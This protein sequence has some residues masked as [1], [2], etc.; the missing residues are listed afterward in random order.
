MHHDV[1]VLLRQLGQARNEPARGKRGH[2]RQRERAALALVGHHVE[3]VALQPLQPARHLA[4]IVRT[5]GRQ[6]HA[7]AGAAKQLHAQKLFQRLDL[8]RHG[9]LRKRKLLRGAGV[10]LVA[11]GD[12]KTGQGLGRWN[13]AAHDE[14]ELE[15]GPAPCMSPLRQYSINS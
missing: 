3:G 11:G 4:A 13:V 10:A 5:G 12:F 2:R 6:H 9:A 14:Q 1:G 8:A 7:V 15:T